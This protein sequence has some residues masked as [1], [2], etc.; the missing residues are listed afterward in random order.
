MTAKRSNEGE[1]YPLMTGSMETSG[2]LRALKNLRYTGIM[3]KRVQSRERER[4]FKP[5]ST[6]TRPEAG[7]DEWLA[8]EIEAGCAE[9]DAG[10][11]IPAEQVWKRLGLE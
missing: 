10:Q 1:A 11:A 8:A 3:K 4:W 2:A 6:A 9:L 7:Y 5:P